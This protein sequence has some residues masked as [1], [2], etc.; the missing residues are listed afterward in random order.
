MII[1]IFCENLIKNAK[2]NSKSDSS[3]VIIPQTMY[4]ESIEEIVKKE[5]AFVPPEIENGFTVKE[6]YP[7][8]SLVSEF[9]L[10]KYKLSSSS[11]E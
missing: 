6:I 5:N 2:L 9:I 4:N 8:N 3:K 11:K 10:T 7:S 1:M